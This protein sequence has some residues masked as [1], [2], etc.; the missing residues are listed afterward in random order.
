M[1]P[2]NDHADTTDFSFLLQDAGMDH[3]DPYSDDGYIPPLEMAGQV[4]APDSAKKT[5]R[6]KIAIAAN[7]AVVEALLDDKLVIDETDKAQAMQA[8]KSGRK[9]TKD[10]L[11]NRP[12]MLMQLDTILS[13]YEDGMILEA[14]RVRNYVQNRLLI[15]S[16]G[17]DAKDRLRALEN[18]GKLSE[19]AAFTERKEITIVNE[20]SES[21]NDSLRQKL[22]A[23]RGRI[24][25][26]EVLEDASLF[27]SGA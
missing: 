19:V 8:F 17:D 2:V 6:D 14:H 24:I 10:E 11:Q 9:I 21:L 5:N 1:T 13:S 16:D 26:G 7:T 12:G 15:E 18:L 23:L 4:P 3:F 27:E 25:E 20:T 22:E